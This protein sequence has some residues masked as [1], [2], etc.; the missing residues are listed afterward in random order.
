MDIAFDLAGF[1]QQ[2][3][4][5]QEAIAEA[6]RPAAQAG[7]Q[8]LYEATLLNVPVGEKEH[9]FY[10]RGKKYGP[11][12]PGSLRDAVYQVFSKD[13]SGPYKAEYHV[14]WNY[15]EA[16]YGFMVHNGTSKSPAHPFVARAFH[17][18][19]N[20]ALQA[21]QARFVQESRNE[22]GVGPAGAVGHPMSHCVADGCAHEASRA[23]RGVATR[24]GLVVALLGKYRRGQAQLV[25]S[26]RG[27]GLNVC[28]GDDAGPRD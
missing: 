17:E 3:R 27:V 10:I 23:F 24:W 20:Q 4:E 16:P 8:V 7:T 21:M 22:H 19:G 25:R 6:T 14:S 5:K 26:D 15:R 13:N 18:H 1:R 2:V 9:Y 11:Y 12:A 28:G